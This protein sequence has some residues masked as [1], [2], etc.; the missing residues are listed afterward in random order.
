MTDTGSF[1]HPSTSSKIH[2]TVAELIDLGADV[3]KVSRH[4]YDTNSLNRLQFL[5]YALAEKLQVD[6]EYQ[7]AHFVIKRRR[8]H[9][10]QFKARGYRGAQLTTHSQSKEL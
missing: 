5:G 10:I 1:K 2:R 7:S 4:I 3:N 6:T 9:Q 8:L